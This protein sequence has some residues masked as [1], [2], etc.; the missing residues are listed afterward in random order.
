MSRAH[1]PPTLIIE[2]LGTMAYDEAFAYQQ[3]CHGRVLARRGTDQEAMYLLLVEHDPPVITVSRRPGAGGHLLATPQA[4]AADGIDVCETNRGG[5]ITYHGPGQLVVY[6]ILDLNVLQLRLHGYMRWLE[7]RVLEVLTQWGLSA[8]RDEAAT[9]VWMEDGPSGAGGKIC[10]IGL[11]VARWISMHG[12]ALNVT[13]E[14]AHFNHIVPCGLAGRS[15]TSL[16]TELG[17][18]CPPMEAVKAAVTESF[19]VAIREVANAAKK[20]S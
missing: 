20:Q 10:A 15:V 7:D 1:P 19:Q 2:D 4:L 16:S 18:Q 9:G 17:D 5:D 13:T 8:R 11:R 14:L 12:L 3:E 6:P